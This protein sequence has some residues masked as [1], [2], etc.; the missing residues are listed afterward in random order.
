MLK[1][2][3]LQGQMEVCKITRWTDKV[4]DLHSGRFAQIGNLILI[5]AKNVK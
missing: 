1:A 3:K 4:Q 2:Y 5:I